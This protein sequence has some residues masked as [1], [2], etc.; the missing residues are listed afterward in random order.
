M[1][2]IYLLSGLIAYLGIIIGGT[3]AAISPEE[4]QPGL[5]RF[6]Y[7]EMIITLFSLYL[8]LRIFGIY[9]WLSLIFTIIIIFIFSLIKI[10]TIFIFNVFPI[11]LFL[12]WKTEYFVPLLISVF[13][14]GFPT[15]TL[16]S[17]D[18]I[19]NEKLTIK[20]PQ[21]YIVIFKKNWIFP[22]LLLIL[23]IFLN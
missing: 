20:L 6:K 3:L 17:I 10:R 9:V 14:L 7:I 4:V 1:E 22:L 19:K 8:I 2:I 16:Y 18:F 23:F 5:A 11:F 21:L 15:G 12:A 13:L